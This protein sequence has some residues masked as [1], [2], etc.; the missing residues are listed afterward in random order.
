MKAFVVFAHGS[1][2]ESANEAVR[3]VSAELAS[4]GGY[5][6][7][8]AFLDPVRPSLNEAV[9]A[10]A[11]RGATDI[12]VIPYFLTLGLHLQRDLPRIGLLVSGGIGTGARSRASALRAP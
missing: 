8:T 9:M 11:A 2:V 4:A 6:V 3:A 10:L 12:V 7:E 5:L 1:S